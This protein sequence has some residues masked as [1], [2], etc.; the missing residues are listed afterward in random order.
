MRAFYRDIRTYAQTAQMGTK[1]ADAVWIETGEPVPGAVF[2]TA[3]LSAAMTAGDDH[4]IFIMNDDAPVDS[5][6]RRMT[7]V[8]PVKMGCPDRTSKLHPDK[9]VEELESIFPLSV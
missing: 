2:V 8:H 1:L 9:V 6:L 5:V 7:N 4:V 3:D